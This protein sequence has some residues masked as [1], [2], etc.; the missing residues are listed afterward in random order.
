[1]KYFWSESFSTNDHFSWIPKWS[2]FVLLKQSPELNIINL[3]VSI[4]A[5]Y[6]NA[7]WD[8][9]ISRYN[10]GFYESIWTIVINLMP[11][12]RKYVNVITKWKFLLLFTNI[13]YLQILLGKKILDGLNGSARSGELTAIMGPSGA[14]KTSLLNVLTGY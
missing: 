13:S 4:N 9:D 14:G 7:F 1:M 6:I 8:F 5:P 2:L 12:K 10:F 11:Q 3:L